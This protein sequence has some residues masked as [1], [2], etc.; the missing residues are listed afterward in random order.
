MFSTLHLSGFDNLV[1]SPNGPDLLSNLIFSVI[2]LS[3]K[4][5]KII[6]GDGKIKETVLLINPAT[7]NHQIGHSS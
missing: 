1:L 3:L 7:H 4:L 6:Y 5:K 2:F